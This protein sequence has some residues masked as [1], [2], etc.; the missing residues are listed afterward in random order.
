[1]DKIVVEEIKEGRQKEREDK[2]LKKKVDLKIATDWIVQKAIEKCVKTQFVV[3]WIPTIVKEVGD[4]F[5]KKIQIGLQV[6]LCKYKV[7][8]LNAQ[9]DLNE[10]L[11]NKHKLGN[12]HK[13]TK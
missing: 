4:I 11:D 7:W 9:H 3:A 12:M 2:W 10:N 8:I 13:G 1:M 6:D 5:P